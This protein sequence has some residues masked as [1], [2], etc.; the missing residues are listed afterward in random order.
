MMYS[1][2]IVMQLYIIHFLQKRIL[3]Q[4]A[5]RNPYRKNLATKKTREQ[6]IQ[7]LLD[8]NDITYTW[9]HTISYLCTKDTT[10]KNFWI[11]FLIEN[12]DTNSMYGLLFLEKDENQHKLYE[13]SCELHA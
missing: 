12:M 6:K 7:K 13:I 3:F 1:P 5:P 8:T 10:N 9:E 11:D 4:K 2:I